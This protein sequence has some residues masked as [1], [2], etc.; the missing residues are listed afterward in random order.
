MNAVCGIVGCCGALADCCE[1]PTAAVNAWSAFP[2]CTVT[3]PT[4]QGLSDSCNII[5]LASTA[6][7]FTGK[8]GAMPKQGRHQLHSPAQRNRLRS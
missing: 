4:C 1:A 5:A 6:V 3:H 8:W 7:T 2:H